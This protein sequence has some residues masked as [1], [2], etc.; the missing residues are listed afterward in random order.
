MIRRYLQPLSYDE[1]ERFYPPG[2]HAPLIEDEIDAITNHYL[3][4]VAAGYGTMRKPYEPDSS[5]RARIEARYGKVFGTV[6]VSAP[7]Q[8]AVCVC[9]GDVPSPVMGCHCTSGECFTCSGE[10]D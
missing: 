1:N 5:L 4:L 6:A 7:K 8:M 10:R 9:C 2:Y 3:D